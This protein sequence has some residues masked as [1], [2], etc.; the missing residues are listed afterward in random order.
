MNINVNEK[1]N[2]REI[3]IKKYFGN[4]KSYRNLCRKYL[5]SQYYE[6][7]IYLDN[8]LVKEYGV[9]IKHSTDYYERIMAYLKK[10]IVEKRKNCILKFFVTAISVVL[11]ILFI[12]IKF[13]YANLFA[14]ICVCGAVGALAIT[15]IFS[16]R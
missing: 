6:C 11:S 9:E 10:D 16:S 7:E 14:I 13:G 5:H 2:L 4:E 12:Y 15:P 3:A 8:Q 1:D